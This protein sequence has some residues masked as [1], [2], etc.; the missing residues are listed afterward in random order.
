M[1]FTFAPETSPLE[2]Y[3]IKRAIHRGGFGEVYY[4]L[5]DSGKEVALKLLN[6]NLEVELRGVR[7][8]LNL[9]HQ[10]L[11]TIFDIRE[12]QDGDHWIVM[13]FIGG[14]GLY[15]TLQL[16]PN[17]MPLDETLHWLEGMT[18]GLSFLHDRGIV[19]R[20]LK[21]ANVFSDQDIVKVGD[22]GLSKYISESRRSAQT[23]SV[24]TVYYMAP[25]VC[26]GRYGREV[27][28]YAMG[29]MLVEMLTGQV[30]FD[31]ETTA[32][33]LMKHMT[34]EPGLSG[35]PEQVQGVIAAALEKDPDK[36]IQDVEELERRFRS[37]VQGLESA[38]FSVAGRASSP[39][40]KPVSPEKPTVTAS[41]PIQ[42][43]GSVFNLAAV[44]ASWKKLPVPV[45]WVVGGIAAFL[46]LETELLG[47]ITRG[48][49]FGISVYLG[50]LLVGRFF[51]SKT[52]QPANAAMQ[53][54]ASP[55]VAPVMQPPPAP[56]PV[57]EEPILSRQPRPPQ[58]PR[59]QSKARRAA[60]KVVCLSPATPRI[61][62]K[63]Q[64]LTDL[65]N[66]LSISLAATFLVTLAVY[67]TTSLLPQAVHAVYFGAVTMLGAWAMMVPCKLREGRTGDVMLRRLT[68]G[69]FGL[70]V[71][72]IAAGLQD[73]LMLS[74]DAL[75]YAE[76]AVGETWVMG[77]ILV[78]N[79]TGFPTMAAFMLF[80]G[81]LFAA[82]RWWWQTDSF[83]RSRFR[84]S[85][86]LVTLLV[87]AVV[88][89]VLHFP[90][91]LGATWALAISAVVQLSAG[92]T[93][94]EERLLKHETPDSFAAE[95]LAEAMPP[96]E[97][98]PVAS[99]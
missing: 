17:G 94:P 49:F 89:G 95:A 99:A 98:M 13:E 88:A 66:S 6:N 46:L 4:A 36:R 78:S 91:A 11:V 24:G 63:R 42:P 12:D 71:G 54:P 50:Y 69:A 32:E 21:P 8:C 82:R 38:D 72:F 25:E 37:A 26:H 81:I 43:T 79:G 7:Q 87:G 19:H 58:P 61:I 1:K 9:K 47:Y 40:S 93:P 29:I 59:Q 62:P 83:R 76:D 51:G 22:V 55:Q 31:G 39:Q 85:S 3:T 86:T 57:V 33:I 2:G 23:Q 10:N 52:N 96:R 65:T 56:Q 77:R 45:K 34:A 44:S 5:S 90:G 73:Y 16:H 41:K 35:V 64:R 84:I 70:G 53:A 28:V 67:L 74:T 20:D 92:W 18:A 15:E 75:M 14:R 97:Q 60:R 48:A 27:D 68:Q 30:P 80:F